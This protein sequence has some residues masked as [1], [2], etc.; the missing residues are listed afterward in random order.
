M[1][2]VE[3]LTARY[4]P[5]LTRKRIWFA[6]AVAVL[7]DMLQFGLGPIGWVFADEAFDVAAMILIS[8]AIGFH[9]LLLPTFLV[10]FIP[11][12]DMLPTWTGCTAV[13]IMLRKKAQAQPPIDVQSQVT[14]VEATPRGEPRQDTF[15]KPPVQRA[16]GNNASSL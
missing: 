7:T 6:F 1:K 8:W 5:P 4:R 11:G 14:S 10:E 2:L 3:D 9:M 13:V 12:P 16:L 15:P